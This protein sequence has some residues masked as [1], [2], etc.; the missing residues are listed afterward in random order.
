MLQYFILFMTLITDGMRF[1]L[2]H[3]IRIRIQ[4]F[5]FSRSL[6]FFQ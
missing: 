6:P 3:E 4:N 5:M 2:T 1:K